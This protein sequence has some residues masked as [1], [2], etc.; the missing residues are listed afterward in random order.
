[1]LFCN[2]YDPPFRLGYK[3]SMVD[4]DK[5]WLDTDPEKREK[6]KRM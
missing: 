5:T 6:K 1:M 4:W 2:A 3:T